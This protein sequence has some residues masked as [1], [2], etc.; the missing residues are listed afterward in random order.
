MKLPRFLASEDVLVSPRQLV[1]SIELLFNVLKR[2][3]VVPVVCDDWVTV[4]FSNFWSVCPA[5]IVCLLFLY[6][7]NSPP[8][9]VACFLRSV[10][11]CSIYFVSC[12]FWMATLCV[13]DEYS[14]TLLLQVSKVV[15]CG[16]LWSVTFNCCCLL[17]PY[18]GRRDGRSGSSSCPPGIGPGGPPSGVV[19][20]VIA[21]GYSLN[22]SSRGRCVSVGTGMCNCTFLTMEVTKSCLWPLHSWWKCCLHRYL[23]ASSPSK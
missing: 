11:E 2:F 12:T 14:L 20:A 3:F 6:C 9:F 15:K 21:G 7:V 13:C 5:L 19:D 8:L 1:H 23:T 4:G 10:S 18:A 17:G 16:G 22:V